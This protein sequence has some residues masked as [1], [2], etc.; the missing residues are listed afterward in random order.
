MKQTERAAL[1]E[2]FRQKKITAV[3]APK[4]LDEGVDV[5]EVDLYH[6]R[7]Q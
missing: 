1:L 3:V 5:L 4:I 7:S 6:H 2:R